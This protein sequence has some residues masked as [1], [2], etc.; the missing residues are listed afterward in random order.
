MSDS[1]RPVCRNGLL[2]LEP[3]QLCGAGR[4]RAAFTTR[5][6]GVSKAPRD[7][8][9]L[10][11]WQ[12]D[13]PESVRENYR[14]LAAAFGANT[15]DLC[16]SKQTHSERVLRV[17]EDFPPRG[18]P[19]KR[20]YEADALISNRP[21]DL[22]ITHHA[23]CV[24]VF[25]FDPTRNAVGLVHAGWRGCALQIAQKTIREMS[26]CFGCCPADMYAAI[27]PSIRKCC[28]E[29]HGDVPIAMRSSLGEKANGYIYPAET[30]GKWHVDLS[31]LLHEQLHSAGI[32]EKQ[33]A[34]SSLCT[35]C[36]SEW[37]YS[38]RRM[39]VERGT[40]AAAM[41]LLM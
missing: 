8:L 14:R 28:F 2:L 40:M 21:G 11:M 41:M 23:D 38:H 10:G 36:R 26:S 12:G 6:G 35:C 22:L 20:N 32:P 29:T 13:D 19:D 18:V 3:I 39:G 7:S 5:I 1:F 16:I 15:E 30:D 34:Q 4:V 37:F 9:N 31:G 25:L 24:P 33:I 27:G 17:T